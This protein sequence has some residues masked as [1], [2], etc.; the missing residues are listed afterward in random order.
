M[1]NDYLNE[2]IKSKIDVIAYKSIDEKIYWQNKIFKYLQKHNNDF[3]AEK[4][5]LSFVLEF[6]REIIYCNNKLIK[7]DIKNKLIFF[8]SEVLFTNQQC[9]NCIN[10]YIESKNWDCCDGFCSV[11]N[12]KYEIKTS[13]K[14]K[15][16]FYGG[17]P[18]G[19]NRFCKNPN[20]IFI[21]LTKGG[22]KM[23][24]SKDLK[25][26]II[27]RITKEEITDKEKLKILESYGQKPD[28]SR[29][30]IIYTKLHNLNDSFN[31]LAKNRI[32]KIQEKINLITKVLFNFVRFNNLYNSIEGYVNFIKIKKDILV[33]LTNI[34]KYFG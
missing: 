23:C 3:I 24:K 22:Y 7:F 28:T 30:T 27:D 29:S 25:F 8:F 16:S 10:G 1:N 19:V 2:I 5:I 13:F 9:I 31:I 15:N 21:C 12:T 17:I 11:C 20:N 33:S 4:W 32:T 26:K 18:E 14:D 6:F 34:S